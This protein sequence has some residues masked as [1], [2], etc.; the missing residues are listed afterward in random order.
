MYRPALLLLGS[1]LEVVGALAVS[2]VLVIC[3]ASA[4]EGWMATRLNTAARVLLLGAAL[5][6]IP[7]HLVAN[8]CAGAVAAGI[9]LWQAK[10][11]NGGVLLSPQ[12]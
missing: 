6:L 2:L 8:L 1:P 7:P 3:F 10:S 9:F 5:A 12:R 11:R 4:F